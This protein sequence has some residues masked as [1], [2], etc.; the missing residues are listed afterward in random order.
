MTDQTDAL[1][2]ALP[3]SVA[4]RSPWNWVA[5]R[6]LG[7]QHRPRIL[8]QLRGLGPDDRLLRFGQRASDEQIGGY[9]D[10]LDFERDLVFGI[11]NRRLRLLAMAHLAFDTPQDAPVSAAEFGVSVTARARGR[12]YGTRLFE[13]A[14]MH[15]RNRQV[16]HLKLHIARENSAMLA[17]VRRA[18]AEL[19]FDGGEATAE[20]VLAQDT[21]A[22]QLEEL[23]GHQAAELDYRVKLHVLRL[24]RLRPRCMK[25][26]PG[27]N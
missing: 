11:F 5:I 9:V 13:H 16:Q 12:G 26:P 6:G 1:E 21:L 22:T 8:T 4:A 20:L 2:A 15:A 17:I 25:G 10:Q 18:G 23:L 27:V 7:P 14:V 19:S 24:D 3:S